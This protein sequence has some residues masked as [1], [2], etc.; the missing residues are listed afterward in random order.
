MQKNSNLIQEHNIL[1]GGCYKQKEIENGWL[2]IGKKY[3]DG[4]W[5]TRD[6][7][8]DNNDYDEEIADKTEKQ[9]KEL[10]DLSICY[11]PYYRQGVG[12]YAVWDE[13]KPK[14]EMIKLNKRI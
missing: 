12:L 3:D 13:T 9:I 10:A 14:S 4:T 1:I 2:L 11:R 7:I 8:I 5:Q 6:I